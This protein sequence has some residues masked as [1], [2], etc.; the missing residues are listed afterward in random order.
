VREHCREPSRSEGGEVSRSA[1]YP[2][3]ASRECKQSSPPSSRKPRATHTNR[4]HRTTGPQATRF[5]SK[6]AHRLSTQASNRSLRVCPIAG[7]RGSQCSAPMALQ[8][9]SRNA[10][11]KAVSRQSLGEPRKSLT[12]NRVRSGALVAPLALDTRRGNTLMAGAWAAP[13]NHAPQR[14]SKSCTSSCTGRCTVTPSSSD[15][16]GP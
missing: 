1:A 2:L 8:S 5:R 13:N 14:L 7:F 11:S 12:A 3:R 10:R 16:I 9:R 4:P 15:T 6:Q